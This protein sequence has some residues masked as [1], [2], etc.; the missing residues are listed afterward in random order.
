MTSQSKP[1]NFSNYDS[2]NRL[3]DETFFLESR[4][5]SSEALFN[6]I[7]EK[8]ESIFNYRE[9]TDGESTPIDNIWQEIIDIPKT[10]FEVLGDTRRDVQLLL[11]ELKYK[12]WRTE[13]LLGT[14]QEQA[15]FLS[16]IETCLLEPWILYQKDFLKS[17]FETIIS[18]ELA[19]GI[20]RARNL[21]SVLGIGWIQKI[22]EDVIFNYPAIDRNSTLIPMDIHLAFEQ[23]HTVREALERLDKQY[24]NRFNAI[25]LI[26]FNR[27]PLGIIEAKELKKHPEG[28]LLKEVLIC[29]NGPF[30]T[31]NTPSKE[32]QEIMHEQGVN[33]FPIIDSK[34][35]VSI[36][37]TTHETITLQETRVYLPSLQAEIRKQNLKDEINVSSK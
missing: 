4:V 17:K 11:A 18:D 1:T 31:L 14:K 7:S 37:Y 25:I 2:S 19:N 34:T 27:I 5:S 24:R 20:T 29:Y 23:R 3:F 9:I 21:N 6:V 30:W 8:V 12:A 28:T 15:I 35:E 26:D 10:K 32:I 22:W 13:I 36:G 16:K 33:I